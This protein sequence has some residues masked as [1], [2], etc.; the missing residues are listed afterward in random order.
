MIREIPI[1]RL[2]DWLSLCQSTNL[3]YFK[4]RKILWSRFSFFVRLRPENTPGNFQIDSE[5]YNS[6]WGFL[7]TRNDKL[8]SDGQLNF[9]TVI[10]NLIESCPPPIP[11]NGSGDAASPSVNRSDDEDTSP[12]HT[13]PSVAT[14]P[15][16]RTGLT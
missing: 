3:A 12:P 11:P 15:R 1:Q 14:V 5:D 8:T 4:N 13:P 16:G 2:I 10:S 9:Q 6:I 7:N